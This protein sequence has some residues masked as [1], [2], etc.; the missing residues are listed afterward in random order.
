MIC[1]DSTFLIDFLDDDRRQHDRARDWMAEHEAEPM[2]APTVVRWEVLRGAA[3]LDG[4]DG[5][6][7]LST[8]LT[9]LESLPLTAAA[10]TE[11]A[12]IEAELRTRGDAISAADYP[13]AGTARNAGATL[14]TA[15]PGFEQV[16]G[17][18]VDRY[19]VGGTASPD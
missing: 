2:Y 7:R 4:V 13:I 19:D 17:L 14:V 18:E 5:V 12:M 15:D 9:W 11:A 8:E 6:E 16:D 3:R 10:A 1:L